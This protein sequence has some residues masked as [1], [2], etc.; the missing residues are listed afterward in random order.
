MVG[1]LF[2]A[3]MVLTASIW[4]SS[5]YTIACE[6][7]SD[8]KGIVVYN[9][10]LHPPYRV[11]CFGSL[12]QA[13][14]FLQNHK[15]D[16]IHAKIV[17]CKTQNAKPF[18]VIPSRLHANLSIYKRVESVYRNDTPS[19][20]RQTFPKRFS[21]HGIE[22]L[23]CDQLDFLPLYNMYY[24]KSKSPKMLVLYDG[25][26]SLR[27]LAERLDK[28]GWIKKRKE[29]KIEVNI[30]IIVLP[31]AALV[32]SD[33]DVL[34]QGAP[35]VAPIISLGKLYID[36]STFHVWDKRKDA[37]LPMPKRPESKLLQWVDEDMTRPYILGM[38]G[39]KSTIL[40]S[41]FFGLGYYCKTG[42]FGLSFARALDDPL[43]RILLDYGGDGYPAVTFVGNEVA[44]S[45]FG[46]FTN[47]AKDSVIAGNIF[48]DNLI[49]NYDPHDYSYRLLCVANVAYGAKHAH[50]FIVSRY[51]Q[52][53]A[54]VDNLSFSNAGC[55]IMLDRASQDNLVQDNTVVANGISG[56]SVQ[57]SP[58]VY[59]KDNRVFLNIRNGL[60][61]RN[62]LDV[63]VVGNVFSHNGS[64]GVELFVKNIDDT[65]D[66]DFDLDPYAKAASMIFENNELCE[67]LNTDIMVKNGAAIALKGDRCGKKMPRLGGDLTPFASRF[68]KN[69]G[70]L[71][72]VGVGEPCLKKGR[73][74]RRMDNKSFKIFSKTMRH[75]LSQNEQADTMLGFYYIERKRYK[76]A[77]Q[78]FKKSS[79]KG[80]TE[81]MMALSYML[82]GEG[83]KNK[84]S[85]ELVKGL[86]LAIEVVVLDRSFVKR[87]WSLPYLLSLWNEKYLYAAWENAKKNMTKGNLYHE[88]K[89]SLNQTLPKQKVMHA[90]KCFYETIGGKGYADFKRY[91]KWEQKR[92]RRFTPEIEIK[93]KRNIL[94]HNA[95]KAL[96]Y[97][98]ENLYMQNISS[99]NMQTIKEKKRYFQQFGRDILKK[100]RK[101]INRILVKINHFRDKKVSLDMVLK[102]FTWPVDLNDE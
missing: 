67:N 33:A 55:G 65:P 34:L 86:T 14:R 24:L 22:I 19:R 91:L 3:S 85:S 72:L 29:G 78:I 6:N 87:I 94:Q 66:R 54:I 10:L 92:Y 1:R 49:Y 56:I 16:F 95:L 9:D 30:P 71:A 17:A 99:R 84:K 40:R 97:R 76:K 74:L 80:N 50:G 15:D 31:S 18:A 12:L 38:I 62:A 5:C 61:V 98:Q 46:F 44:D 102:N 89:T 75:T 36:R 60:T 27:R 13:K 8:K 88:R 21:G 73:A 68:L 64:N 96:R 53:S 20:L 37:I 23:R 69:Q 57:E 58:G 35:R 32:I 83:A 25:T 52:N 77:K 42:T 7:L 81:A 51:V 2:F 48:H 28:S 63:Q 47:R 39:S 41:R 90:I 4:A 26:Y 93:V 100:H 79:L 11:G 43:S 82:M 70:R 59:V 45:I 101:E